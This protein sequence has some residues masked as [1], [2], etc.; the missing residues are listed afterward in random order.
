MPKLDTEIV[1]F[2]DQV[3]D[4]WWRVEYFDD[5]GGCYMAIFAGVKAEAPEREITSLRSKRAP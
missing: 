1:V 4:G 5:D 2:E 3:M